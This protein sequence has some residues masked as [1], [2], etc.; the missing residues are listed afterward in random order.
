M[1]TDF[2]KNTFSKVI[3]DYDSARPGYPQELYDKVLSFSGIGKDADVLEVG[4]GTGQA[5]DLFL[6]G[7][8]A[9][10]LLEVS[11]EQVLFL[12][13]KYRD[14]PKVTVKKDYFEQY[15]TEK[16]YDL[17][18]SATAFHWVD[19]WIGYPKAW[20][21][22]K[23]GGTLAV[24]WHMSS[25]TFYSGGI[26]D[27]LNALKKKYL[28]QEFLGFDAEGIQMV[29]EK[30]IAQIQSGGCFGMPEIYEY[31]WTDTYDADRYVTLLN[32]YSGT[33][34]LSEEK[35]S[36][37][38]A[39]VK[40]HIMANG[41][42][43]ELPQHVMLYLVKKDDKRTVCY[44]KAGA[45]D[46]YELAVLKG[47]V[48]NTTY[49][50]IYPQEKLTGYDVEKNKRIFESIVEN[51]ELSLYVATVGEKIVGFMTCGK[52]YKSFREYEQEIGLLYIL[53][54]YQ[55]Q[56][57]GTAFFDIARKQVA[58]NGYK[59]FFLSVNKRNYDAQRFYLAMGGTVLC[60]EGEQVRVGYRIY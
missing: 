33:Q 41:G 21:M 32:T 40:A 7:E 37:Y 25:V 1:D 10:D 16:K 15:E 30:R 54:K 43:V 47:K 51:P 60:E 23:P 5:T 50:G 27:G 31:R 8:F 6:Q 24:F 9:F 48:W 29:K 2:L 42:M 4:A 58:E 34:A 35:R 13:Q 44:R 28:P 26:F 17:I 55:R 39:E 59:E 12:K 53:K 45:E 57:I 20:E 52:P 38:L 18:Y 11:E 49:Q 36:A 3:K 56:G 19:S 46:C 22:L 14:N